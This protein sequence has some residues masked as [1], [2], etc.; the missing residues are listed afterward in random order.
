MST[1]L[2]EVAT[3]TRDQEVASLREEVS[4]L[5]RQLRHLQRLA[6]VGTM[7]AKVVH[8]FNNI[9]TTVLGRVQL[10]G[11]GDEES[12]EQAL[13]SATEAYEQATATCKSLL[14]LTGRESRQKENL[15]VAKLV[16][17][18]LTAMARD[19]AKDGI[20]LIKNVPPRL[21]VTARPLEIKQVLLN[22]LLNA[23]SAVLA[24]PRPRHVRIT[25]AKDNGQVLIRV[26][27]NGVGIPRENLEQIFEPFF[28]TK[29]DEGTGLGL[30]VCREIVESLNGRLSVRSQPGKGSCF[31]VALPT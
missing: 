10:A 27:D 6:A 19:P 23:R 9:L 31:T 14:D 15:S 3:D 24:K 1:S 11:D 25:A 4:A 20:T 5:R 17:E 22:L 12:R 16:D 28:T 7:T 30:P 18:I 26:A 13:R 29:S 21:R 2:N 8:E